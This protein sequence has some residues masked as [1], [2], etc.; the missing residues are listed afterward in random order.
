MSSNRPAAASTDQLLFKSSSNV[1]INKL[2][3]WSACYIHSIC[4][5]NAKQRLELSG[6]TA[7]VSAVN[8]FCYSRLHQKY[9]GVKFSKT[10]LKRT[11]GQMS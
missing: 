3:R 5:T 11:D 7:Q 4:K 10:E 8:P 2:I 1:R 6:N 9:T